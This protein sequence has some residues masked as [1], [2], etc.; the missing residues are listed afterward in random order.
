MK[1]LHR[2]IAYLVLLHIVFIIPSYY[3]FRENKLLLFAVEAFY[4]LSFCTGIVLV[5]LMFKPLELIDT[6]TELIGEEDFS[7]TFRKTGQSELDS[8][9]MLF[10]TMLERLRLE[11]LT[12]K[13]QHFFLQKLMNEIPSGIIILDYDGRIDI[14]NPGAARIFNLSNGSWTGKELADIEIP[15]MSSVFRL[16]NNESAVYP[17]KGNRRLKCYKSQFI[18]SGFPRTFILIEDVTR[19]IR[20][21]EK[22]AYEKLIRILSH[23]INNSVG[24]VGS[25]LQ[26]CHNYT[27]YIDESNRNDFDNALSVSISRLRNLNDFTKSYADVIRLPLPQKTENNIAEIIQQCSDLF[28]QESDT[29]SILWHFN[30]VKNLPP[31]LCDKAQM[32][33]VFINIYKNAV[34]A[35]ASDGVIT[36]DASAYDGKIQ[37]V[38]GDNGCGIS[39]E[40]RNNLFS[41]FY[42][43][44]KNGQ[45]IGLTLVSEILERHGFPFSLETSSDGITRFT[46][47]IYNE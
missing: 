21:S 5:R 36:V 11:R 40:V 45:G 43:N 31:V 9:I 2:F 29:K 46:F 26:S 42:S 4:V 6:G 19:E 3:V 7:S 34:E 25:M 17:Y 12:T 23:E 24:A 20:K 32:E 27:E 14:M 41:P 37:I 44:K 13:E 18:D 28:R 35:I 8:L 10:N 15:F 16:K 33:Q 38:I 30:I 39:D 1:L 22:R 47:E